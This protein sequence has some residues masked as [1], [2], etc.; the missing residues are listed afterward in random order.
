MISWIRKRRHDKI[1]EE[2]RHVASSIGYLASVLGSDR[3]LIRGKW[4]TI[5]DLEL[6]HILDELEEA[7][8]QLGYRIIPLD[9]WIDYAGW[10][11]SIDD[12][13][14]QKRAQDERPVFTKVDNGRFTRCRQ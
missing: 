7:Y 2:Y 9:Y 8:A 10:G 3:I 12:V 5:Q 11:V 14:L 6:F 1:V 4:F 13:W